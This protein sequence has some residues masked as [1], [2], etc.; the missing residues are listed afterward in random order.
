MARRDLQI[1]RRLMVRTVLTTVL[2]VAAAVVLGIEFRE[3]VAELGHRF[4]DR[5]GLLGMGIGVLMIDT[6]II[7]L[8]TDPLLLVGVSGELPFWPMFA[9]TTFASVCSGPAGYICGALLDRGTRVGP[10]LRRR[11]PRFIAFLD[12]HHLK[13]VVAAAL[14]PV[15]F[16]ATTWS[17]GMMRIGFWKVAAISLLRIPKTGFY[18]W[19]IWKGWE[20]GGS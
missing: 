13:A 16:S 7:P 20:Y 6:S 19:L 5:F 8:S 3:P 12:E 1:D 14:L 11:F 2:I 17:A 15:P 4:V 9:V 10:F 18:L